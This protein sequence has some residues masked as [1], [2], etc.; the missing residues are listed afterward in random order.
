MKTAGAN[1]EHKHP[2]LSRIKSKATSGFWITGMDPL[3]F[4]RRSD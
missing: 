4:S 3:K 2:P 1:K